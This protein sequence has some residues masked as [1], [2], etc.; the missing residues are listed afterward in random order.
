MLLCVR[1][2]TAPAKQ[3]LLPLLHAY[4][5]RSSSFV[6]GSGASAFLGVVASG[7]K[8]LARWVLIEFKRL[9]KQ[10]DFDA[11]D[12]EVSGHWLVGY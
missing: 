10:L 3:R 5:F 9:D 7:R 4:P 6:D 12:G 1:L 2:L 11:K 8:S